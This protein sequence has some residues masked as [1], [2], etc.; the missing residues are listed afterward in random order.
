MGVITVGNQMQFESCKTLFA[1]IKS[2]LDSFDALDLIDNKDLYSYVVDVISSLG[3]GYYMEKQA[4]LPI[5]RYKTKLPEDFY[6]LYSAFKV[7]GDKTYKA[8]RIQPQTGSVMYVENTCEKIEH[9][10]C[11][12]EKVVDKVTVRTYIDEG[13]LEYNFTYPSLLKLVSNSRNS[14]CAEDS[15]NLYHGSSEE[16][17]IDNGYIHSNFEQGNVYIKYYGFPFDEEGFPMIPKDR[18]LRIAIEYY[19]KYKLF[20]KWWLNS[21]APDVE[22]KT[23]TMLQRYNEAMSDASTKI[24]TPS[25]Q[26]MLEYR[27]NTRNRFDVYQFYRL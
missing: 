5:T 19:I 13:Q 20:E 2:D 12:I 27:N 3:I 16:I 23:M 1:K 9:C 6:L 4:V 10:K 18:E 8:G 24:K 15:P 26:T 25:F 7:Q 14:F 17:S 22:R 21:D 11:D